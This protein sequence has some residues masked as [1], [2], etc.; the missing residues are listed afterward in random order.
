MRKLIANFMLITVGKQWVDETAPAEVQDAINKSKRKDYV[1]I[2]HTVDFIHLADFLTKPYSKTPTRDLYARIRAA[3]TPEDIRALSSDLPM[4]NWQRYF[5][6]LL[7][8]EDGFIQKRW[9]ELYEYR[10]KVAHNAIFTRSDYDRTCTL[11]AELQPLLE[12]A[13]R[14][15]PQ[16]TV[17]PGERETVVESAATTLSALVGDFIS[18]WRLFEGRLLRK[19]EEFE[20]RVKPMSVPLALAA[21][22]RAKIVD[23]TLINHIGAVSHF[24]NNLVHNTDMNI[25]EDDIRSNITL[26]LRIIEALQLF[27]KDSEPS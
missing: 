9:A 17:P 12:E 3:K 10:C 20:P 22:R 26:I 19:A 5:A 16:V 1:N 2:L 27:P 7:K 18:A 13:L 4:S 6:A 15:L 8:C 11:T 21:L 23:E 14:K 24:R 25:S